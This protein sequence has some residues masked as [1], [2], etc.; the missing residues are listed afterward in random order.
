MLPV[1]KEATRQPFTIDQVR[2][3]LKAAQGDWRG[4]IM[5]ALYTAPDFK[6]WLICG[7][8]LWTCLKPEPCGKQSFS[9]PASPAR[10]GP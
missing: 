3:I 7:G 9:Y 5:V 6:T 2:A 10:R 4:A 8:N 1:D